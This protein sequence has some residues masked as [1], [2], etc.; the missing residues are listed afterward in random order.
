MEWWK[1]LAIGIGG[2]VGSYI[3]IKA[4]APEKAESIKQTMAYVPSWVGELPT[5]AMEQMK[6]VSVGATEQMAEVST[7]AMEAVKATT[8]PITAAITTMGETISG[9]LEAM[10]AQSQTFADAI[11]STAQSGF[12]AAKSAADAAAK[13]AADAAARAKE[14]A[15][16]WAES[17]SGFGEKLSTGLNDAV[18]TIT[19]PLKHLAAAPRKIEAGLVG[20]VGGATAGAATGLAL[21][22]PLGPLA[23]VGGGIGAIIGWFL[24]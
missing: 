11:V 21:S 17:F 19:D 20:G 7:G 1:M 13:A 2:G 16:K 3:I 14:E 6:A 23:L 22:A 12:D 15:D 24:G 4:V 10:K 9:A 8:E 18:K 5:K